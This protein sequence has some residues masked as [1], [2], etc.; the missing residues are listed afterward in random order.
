M[1]GLLFS[2]QFSAVAVVAAQDLFELVAGSRTRLEICAVRFGQ[3]T[4]ATEELLPVQLIRAYT[5]SGSGGSAATPAPYR[6]W[7][8]AATS[9]AEVNNTTI[10]TSGTPLTLH[11]DTWSVLRGWRFQPG[12]P[13]PGADQERIFIEKS[14][15]FVVRLPVAPAASMTMYGT[16]VF[17]EIGMIGP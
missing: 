12:H 11:A 4:K 5:T 7:S 1:D 14:E 10:A 16:L 9:T 6:P 17:R 15:R 13:E 2:V 3:I 8:R